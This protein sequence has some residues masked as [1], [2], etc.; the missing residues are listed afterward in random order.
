MQR[1]WKSERKNLLCDW[2]GLRF[3]CLLCLVLLGH[4]LYVNCV[5]GGCEASLPERRGPESLSLTGRRSVQPQTPCSPTCLPSAGNLSLP[6]SALGV[7]LWVRNKNLPQSEFGNY[8]V[9]IVSR[10]YQLYAL[11]GPSQSAKT[12]FIKSSYRNPFVVTVQGITTLNC[13]LL[14]MACTMRC[15]LV[16]LY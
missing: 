12:S 10:R 13:P 4:V 8:A 3:S 7:S 2:D 14:N 9:S 5:V 16:G 6:V 15:A 11:Q 1:Q